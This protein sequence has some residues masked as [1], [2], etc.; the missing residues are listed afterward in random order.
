MKTL[1]TLLA[2]GLFA[3]CSSTQQEQGQHRSEQGPPS[4]PIVQYGDPK[5]HPDDPNNPWTIENL[6]PVEDEVSA[7]Q[8]RQIATFEI[9]S[10]AKE[11]VIEGKVTHSVHNVDLFMIAGKE[12][13]KMKQD[14][15][16]VPN[17]VKDLGRAIGFSFPVKPGVKYALWLW[18]KDGEQPDHIKLQLKRHYR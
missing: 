1:I 5:P 16:Y 7:G 2:L 4:L 17:Q 13:E 3:L 14:P 10:G 8:K 15:R 11:A 12:A 18:N 9:P 6:T